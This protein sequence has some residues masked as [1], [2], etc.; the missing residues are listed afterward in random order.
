M[1]LNDTV[2]GIYKITNKVNGKCYIGQS[3]NIKKRLSQHKS[4]T[5]RN[6]HINKILYQAIKKYGIEN[7]TFDIIEKCETNSLDDREKYWIEYYD[8][9]NNG[10]NGAKGG[11]GIS[12]EYH[13]CPIITD[14]NEMILLLCDECG[15]KCNNENDINF[16]C[17]YD[18]TLENM[19][20][21]ELETYYDGYITMTEDFCD[22]YRNFEDWAEC[23]LI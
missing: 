20:T 1:V 17:P 19:D 15:L 7:F 3:I 6:I 18:E 4:Q 22:G 21:D 8:S 16:N 14:K 13:T 11:K 10:Y 9:Y 2:S 12:S 23:N 5:Y